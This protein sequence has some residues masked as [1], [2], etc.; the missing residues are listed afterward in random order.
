MH[1]DNAKTLLSGHSLAAIPELTARMGF[2]G[3]A[4][5]AAYLDRVNIPMGS[6]ELVTLT[7][8]T[9]ACYNISPSG[10]ELAVTRDERDQ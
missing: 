10:N 7:K 9:R 1:Q 8:R 5:I 6:D 3:K 2:E 4:S